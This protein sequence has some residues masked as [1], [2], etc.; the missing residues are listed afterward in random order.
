MIDAAINHIAGQLNQYLKRTFDL[1]EDIV[2]VSNILEQD[3]TVATNV[4]NKLA[5]FLIN[6]EKDTVPFRPQNKDTAGLER[7]IVNYP[8][9]YLNLYLMVAGHFNG[10]NYPEALKFLSNTISFF[11]RHPV[12]DHE[13]TP[14]LDSRIEKLILDIENLNIRDL[15][16]LWSAITGKYLP[17]IIYKVR[18]VAF[19][20]DD[21]RLRPP[22]I[23]ETHATVQT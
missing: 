6:V 14:D 9:I 22:V 5:I 17:S 23:E 19:D 7:S 11:Q 12:L 18:M 3:G 13:N 10:T 8:P 16:T 20:T 15:S 4:D 21:I 1:N 2:V